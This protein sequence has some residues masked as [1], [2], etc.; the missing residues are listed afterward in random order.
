MK[1]FFVSSGDSATDANLNI[2][3]KI[4]LAED[5]TIFADAAIRTNLHQLIEAHDGEKILFSMTHGSND[6]ISDT[7]GND[8]LNR[9]DVAICDGYQI[10]AWACHTGRALG[11]HYA[12][13]GATWWGYDCAITAPDDRNEFIDIFS[14]L[15][16]DIK[17]T[18]ANGIDQQSVLL[19][20]ENIKAA[21]HTA[22]AEL[23]TI[24]A[25]ND[26]YAMSLFCC[27]RQTWQHLRVW[28]SGSANS[29]SHPNAVPM[30][31]F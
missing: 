15:I 25:Q 22:E 11:S 3:H 23:Y 10:F 31:I 28:L 1:I 20:L 18:F 24:G 13:N 9:S 2:A 16:R 30:S 17:S 27:C 29:I 12:Q 21:C 4:T 8:A 6:S 7:V 26:Q 19:A 5:I 14:N